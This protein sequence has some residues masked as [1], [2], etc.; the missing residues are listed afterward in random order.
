MKE[1]QL[2]EMEYHALQLAKTYFGKSWRREL[3]NCWRKSSY[4]AAFRLNIPELQSLRN[5]LG[6]QVMK[7]KI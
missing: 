5:K 7:L 4:P 2:S 1:V 6:S 3:A